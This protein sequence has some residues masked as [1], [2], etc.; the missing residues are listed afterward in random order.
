MPLSAP[1]PREH[2]HTRRV[3]CQGFRRTDG[4]W[5]IEG[6]ITDVKTYPFENDFR[7][8]I[9]PGDPIHDM[10]IRLT[11][12]DRFEVRAVEAV[13]DKSPYAV[14][15]AITPN[16]QRLIGLRIRSG[17]TQKVKELLGGVEGCTH[18]VELL[19]PVATT[20]FQTI[21]PVL[22][23]ER[24]RGGSVDGDSPSAPAARKRPPLLL[25][26]CH[27]FRSDGEVTRKQW[28]EHYTGND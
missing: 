25:N 20:A 21:F 4:L 10:W 1:A 11:V 6:H 27:A 19:G 18:L 5:D 14:C 7:G 24:A 26:T 17:W 13:T 9:E 15:P 12:D 22:A 2:I 8:P 23:R 16:F 3:T 28:P